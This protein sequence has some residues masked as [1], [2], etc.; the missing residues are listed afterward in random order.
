M[1][2]GTLM[3]P[4]EAEPLEKVFLKSS[5]KEYVESKRHYAGKAFACLTGHFIEPTQSAWRHKNVITGLLLEE[6]GPKTHLLHCLGV[7]PF[8][9]W[10]LLIYAVCV[11]QLKHFQ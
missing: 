4:T 10:R 5:L 2:G 8:S 3:L 1:V 6:A 11:S 9:L 7:S